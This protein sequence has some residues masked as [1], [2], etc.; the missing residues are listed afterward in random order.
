VT[1]PAKDHK[2]TVL[3]FPT[4]AAAETAYAA[5]HHAGVNREDMTLFTR[6]ETGEKHREDQVDEAIEI[7]GGA[8]ASIGASAGGVGGLLA[9]LGMLVIPGIGPILAVGPIAAALTGA[10]TGGAFGGFAGSLTGLGVAEVEA[11]IAEQHVRAGRSVIL[12]DGR[13]DNARISA[14]AREAGALDI[15]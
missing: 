10:I 13:A 14:I 7:G 2:H 6:A 15:G 1:H 11:K 5:L 3:V 8:G 4:R 12:L 9:G